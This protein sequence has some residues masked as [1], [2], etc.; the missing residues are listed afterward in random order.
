MNKAGT[1]IRYYLSIGVVLLIS[2]IG[3]GGCSLSTAPTFQNSTPITIGTSISTSGDFSDDGKALQEGYQLWQ[4]AV[5][6]SGGLLGRPV[7]FDFLPDDSTPQKVTAN[8]Q[9]MITKNHD[10]LVVGPYSTLLTRAASAVASHYNYALIE[11]AGTAPAVFGPDYTDLFSVSLSAT[12]YLKSFVYFI[13][14]L[15]KAQRPKTI[16]YATSDDFFTQPQIDEA[17]SLLEAGGEKTALYYP[18][19]NAD[20]TKDYT[21]IV[22]AIIAAHPD[23]V[24]LGTT[25]Q[26]DCVAFMQAFKQRNFNPAAIIA[27]AGPD[28]GGQFTGPLGGPAAAEGIFVPNGGWYP[29]VNNFGNAQFVSDYLARYGGAAS[30]ISADTV[31]AYS[32]GQVLAQAVTKA[33]SI[34]NAQLIQE[35]HKDTF[36]T[37]Q[38]PVKFSPNGENA[39]AV[40]FLFQWQN[41]QLVVVYPN[42]SAQKNPEYPKHPWSQ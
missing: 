11:G 8:Y 21:P 4:N 25:G 34:N 41:G 15:P 20:T 24:I 2:L 14:S 26:Q 22:N 23:V 13:L 38:G 6:N 1:A 33:Q 29:T 28:Q 12:S 5:N 16:A 31:E 42:Y 18:P 10:D 32:V 17:Q 19:W 30:D 7:Q 40:A 37:L 39:I 36:N 35:L 3:A 27:T 9:Q